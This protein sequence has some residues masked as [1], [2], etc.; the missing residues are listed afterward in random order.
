MKR[1]PELSLRQPEAT[2]LLRATGF[3]QVQVGKFYNNLK[4]LKTEKNIPVAR[5]YNVD[6]SGISTV[7]KATNQ[8]VA[9]KEMK[10]VG[11]LSS[12][13]RG[14]IIA[15]ICAMNTQEN[16]IPPFFIFPHKKLV[17]ALLYG[18]PNG[19]K[20]KHGCNTSRL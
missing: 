6:E 3:N 11:K 4:Q 17:P 19:A 20:G 12:S 1:Y 8:I 2:S 7:T 16:F 13:E 14:K 15:I 10:Q 5:I 9:S 18:A